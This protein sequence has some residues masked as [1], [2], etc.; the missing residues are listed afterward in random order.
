MVITGKNRVSRNGRQNGNGRR[1][2][3]GQA[4]KRKSEDQKDEDA[5]LEV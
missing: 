3:K 5:P 1:N 4:G 2:V